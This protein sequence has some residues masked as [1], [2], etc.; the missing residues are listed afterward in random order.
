MNTYYTNRNLP[1]LYLDW[2]SE[3][4][5]AKTGNIDLAHLVMLKTQTLSKTLQLEHYS[6]A[7]AITGFPHSYQLAAKHMLW[8]NL[9]SFY[10]QKAAEKLSPYTVRT[11]REDARTLLE[12]LLEVNGRILL[13]SN[14]QQR[15]G[16]TVV[17]SQEALR[18]LKLS[19][20]V[21]VQKVIENGL[22][23]K[24][25]RFNLR[26]YVAVFAHAGKVQFYLYPVAKLVYADDQN[27]L[28]TS[29]RHFHKKLP[30]TTSNKALDKDMGFDWFAACKK[31]IKKTIAAHRSHFLRELKSHIRYYDHFGADLLLTQNQEALVLEFNRSPSL[32]W[33]YQK[34]Y[35]LKKEMLDGYLT[36]V[37]Q[38]V[39]LEAP[40]IVL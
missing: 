25:R 19:D 2:L 18:K 37:S 17:T 34:D 28:I 4:G 6:K 32:L 9:T 20:Y 5:I 26:M 36:A 15:Q 1:Q 14:Y 29:N 23:I 8:H 39:P 40:W 10:G 31:V 11:D 24:T 12:E 7:K 22:R 30:L 35:W 38:L 13:K 3:R 33:K 27:G 16:L 21:V